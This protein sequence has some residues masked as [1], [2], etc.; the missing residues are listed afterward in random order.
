VVLVKL[1]GT[2]LASAALYEPVVVAAPA[3][4]LEASTNDVMPVTTSA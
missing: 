1:A 4:R 3:T 2:N